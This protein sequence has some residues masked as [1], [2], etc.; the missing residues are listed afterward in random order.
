MSNSKNKTPKLYHQ[1]SQTTVHSVNSLTSNQTPN[2]TQ[3]QNTVSPH[4]LIPQH[5]HPLGEHVKRVFSVDDGPE[6]IEQ[7]I[8]NYQTNASVFTGTATNNNN[9]SFSLGANKTVYPVPQRLVNMTASSSSQRIPSRRSPRP[10]RYPS[11]TSVPMVS[12]PNTGSTLSK[13]NSNT[14]NVEPNNNANANTN[15]TNA[16][17]TNNNTTNNNTNVNK[18]CSKHHLTE[19][20]EEEIVAE[21]LA[22]TLQTLPSPTNIHHADYFN[23]SDIINMQNPTISNDQVSM[24]SSLESYTLR[25]RQDAINETHPFGIRIWK[26]ALYKKKRSVQSAAAEDIHET[27]LKKITWFVKISNFVW[28]STLGLLL[29][30]IYSIAALL[31]LTLGLFT[32]SAREYASVFFNLAKYLLWPFGKVVFLVTNERYWE[33]DKDE[34]ISVQQFYK[35]ATSYKNRL[36]FHQSQTQST[37]PLLHN[38]S[39]NHPS[40]DSIQRYMSTQQS[41]PNPTNSGNNNTSAN[42]RVPTTNQTHSIPMNQQFS[43]S[44][45]RSYPNINDPLNS[46]GNSNLGD[47]TANNNGANRRYFGRGNWTFGRI[48]FYICFHLFVQPIGLLLSLITWLFV[49]TIPMSNILWNLMYHCRKHPLALGFKSLKNNS[50]SSR[51]IMNTSDDKNILLCTF[52]A[53][54]WHY[55]KFTVD[56][57]NV[58][59]VNL[60]SIVFFTIFDFYVLKNILQ[61]ESA[62]TNPSNIFVLCLA[63]IIPL[64]FYIGQA[65]ASISAQTSMGLGAVLNAFFSTIVEIYLYCVALNQ[66]KGRLV[67]G[68][69]VGSILG[70]ILLLPGLS[71]CGG[72]LKRK[73]QRYN[74]AS[75]GV[76]SALLIFSMIVMSVP[77]I[78]FE[79]YSGYEVICD[80]RGEINSDI[81]SEQSYPL[82]F[83]TAFMAIR[84]EKCYFNRPPLKYNNMF[85]HVLIPLSVACTIALFLAYSIGLWF[86]LRTHAKL[87]WQLPIADQQS[88]L[89]PLSQTQSQTASQAQLQ[90]NNNTNKNTGTTNELVP[91]ISITNNNCA[92]AVHQDG[93][94]DA[95][96]WSRSKSTLILLFATLLYAM[97]AEILVDCVD[98]VLEDFPSLDPKILGLTIFA[99]V[100]N[101][102]EFLNAISFAINGNVALS[103]EIGSAY[104]LQVCLLQI[105]ALV[106]YSIFYTWNMNHSKVDIS[107]QMFALIFERWDF[108]SLISSTLLFTY[109]YAE[110]KSNYFKGS[111][112]VLLYFVIILSFYFQGVV[113][114]L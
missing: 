16:N 33:E 85:T 30:I 43:Q 89:A 26:P 49:F 61:L 93:G 36:F 92:N 58:I 9:S 111:M 90:G 97:I 69:I 103:M 8:R 14:P 21:V 88:Q 95:P 1:S 94:H 22:H 47:D 3:I 83:Q 67:E 51:S 60:I 107:N 20:E 62:L 17:A 15:V 84:E 80:N 66:N 5:S 74:P 29:F 28:L 6:E 53:A 37:D 10:L 76:S 68:S 114:G 82:S 42:A 77:T 59:V 46:D 31:V 98:T 11:E 24:T 19:E 91:E 55:Y 39:L 109:L 12:Q 27:K 4:V 70:A 44:T 40:Y 81:K 75:A 25:E 41:S 110:G 96:N 72:A 63:S 100:P 105:P 108:F 7:D 54:G 35:W 113:E 87:I 99:L 102:T 18:S 34:G 78:F 112:M 32:K 13:S 38:T 104:A 64:A 52:R 71:M 50:S 23:A 57:T 2:T 56:G 86:T 45:M 106:I 73:T 48:I 79:L 101:T 65:V